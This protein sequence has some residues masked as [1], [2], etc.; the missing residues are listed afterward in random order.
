MSKCSHLYL[1]TKLLQHEQLVSAVGLRNLLYATACS[2][3]GG[4]FLGDTDT[5]PTQSEFPGWF[6]QARPV[7]SMKQLVID[8]QVELQKIKWLYEQVFEQGQQED[9]SSDSYVWQGR[10]CWL[11]LEVTEDETIASSAA[12]AKKVA[13]GVSVN[14]GGG[15]HELCR[16]SG[17]LLLMQAGSEGVE[18]ACRAARME[19]YMGEDN[20]LGEPAFVF[21]GAVNTWQEVEQRL[22]ADQAVHADQ[23]G[24]YVHIRVVITKLR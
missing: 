6:L 7:S 11:C 16:F 15:E 20:A 22:R 21:R 10:S 1:T 5:S 24:D 2:A 4:D 17:R 23:D 9:L 18:I 3:A 12:A 13:I 19:G 14:L 8:F